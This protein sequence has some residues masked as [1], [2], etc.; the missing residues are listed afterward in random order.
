MTT[1]VTAL[2]FRLRSEKATAKKQ[3]NF[4][5]KQGNQRKKYC[6]EC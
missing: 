4:I 5:T 6:V 1:L 3:Q 2:K